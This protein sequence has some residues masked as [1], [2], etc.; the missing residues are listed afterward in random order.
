MAAELCDLQVHINGQQTF[1]LHEKTISRFSGKLRKI[2]KKEKKRTQI[3]KTGIEINDF[4]GGS[5]GFELFSRFCYNNGE[6]DISVLN[7]SLLHCCAVFL[8]M[9]DTLLPKTSEI[10]SRMSDWSWT[11]IRDC[12]KNCT[13]FISYAESFG[14]LEKLISNLIIKI[15]QNSYCTTLI[16]YSSSSSS[17]DSSTIKP[18]ST[19]S[20]LS[21]SSSTKRLWWFDDLTIL[22]PLIIER[23]A[24]DL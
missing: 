8:G 14:I 10:L 16:P 2:I 7:I 20:R 24:K 17:P 11:D 19:L 3:R 18:N 21:S 6:I 9:N 15:T 12:L 1:Y 22:P 23:F 5:D 13:P 4:P